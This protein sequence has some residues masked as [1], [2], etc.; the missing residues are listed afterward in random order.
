MDKVRLGFTAIPR[1]I[2]SC[3]R[4]SIQHGA[5]P[6]ILPSAVAMTRTA[7]RQKSNTSTATSTQN[8]ERTESTFQFQRKRSS[9]TETI[10][11]AEITCA[12]RRPVV[13]TRPIRC[14]ASHWEAP[15]EI[16]PS[17]WPDAP[18]AILL[19]EVRA[20]TQ[21]KLSARNQHA[22]RLLRSRLLR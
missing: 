14:S 20:A 22:P 2:S 9:G 21:R 16:H 10:P 1:R 6:I 12:L 8:A 13:S 17:E 15:H 11:M 5:C 3:T 18:P 4:S 19:C 7:I